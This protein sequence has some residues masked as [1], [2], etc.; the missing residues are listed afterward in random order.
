MESGK[1]LGNVY[2]NITFN[3][4]AWLDFVNLPFGI[5]IGINTLFKIHNSHCMFTSIN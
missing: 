2:V 3:K 4:F 1:R 5:R